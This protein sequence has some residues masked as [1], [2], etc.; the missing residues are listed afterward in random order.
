[1]LGLEGVLVEV[2]VDF[3]S[4][5]PH[6]TVVGLP[7]T[8]EAALISGLEVLPIQSLGELKRHLTGEELIPPFE[9][10]N[11]KEDLELRVQILFPGDQRP[12]PRQAGP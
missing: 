3:G 6:I 4:G 12:G 10:E 2:E 5:L 11:Q 9:P 1:M 7:D 8:A